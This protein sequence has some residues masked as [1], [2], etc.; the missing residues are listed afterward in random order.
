MIADMSSCEAAMLNEQTA[1]TDGHRQ[2][3]PGGDNECPLAGPPLVGPPVENADR[4]RCSPGV[5]R[6]SSIG[7][8]AVDQPIPVSTSAID[9]HPAFSR[10]FAGLPHDVQASMSPAQLAALSR[11]MQ[12]QSDSRRLRVSLPVFGR[13]YYL[14]VFL[15]R[16]RRGLQRLRQEGQLSIPLISVV[17]FVLA[18]LAL[19]SLIAIILLAT[20]L[21]KS[22][23]GIDLLDGPSLLHDL[24]F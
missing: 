9:W 23:L 13:R 24:F 22:V 1:G 8:S 21:L 14:A 20:Y 6:F 15:G 5:E 11:V 10:L 19:P 17:M 16:E 3:V 2:P 12:P 7:A 18:G 4:E